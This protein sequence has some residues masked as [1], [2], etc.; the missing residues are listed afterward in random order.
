MD[1]A[2]FKVRLKVE[3]QGSNRDIYRPEAILARSGKVT[4]CR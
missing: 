2:D 3:F 1:L 4:G